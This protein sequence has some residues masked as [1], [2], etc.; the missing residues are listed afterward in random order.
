MARKED[1][2]ITMEKCRQALGALGLQNSM[3]LQKIGE[4]AGWGRRP[5]LPAV[6]GTWGLSS[7]GRQT[8]VA[9][10][11]WPLTLWQRHLCGDGVG[12][13]F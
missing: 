12:A 6:A 9:V 1:P 3:A 4:H 13:S 2:G 7:L 11:A 8:S 5:G 10:Q